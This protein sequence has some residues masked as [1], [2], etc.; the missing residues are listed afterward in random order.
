MGDQ[1]VRTRPPVTVGN[2]I[3]GMHRSIRM[4]D[5]GSNSR[6]KEI[7]GTMAKYE[8][9]Q[10]LTQQDIDEILIE[11]PVNAEPDPEPEMDTYEAEVWSKV[12]PAFDTLREANRWASH[13]QEAAFEAGYGE[14]WSRDGVALYPI[15]YVGTSAAMKAWRSGSALTTK[16][17]NT[18]ES[19]P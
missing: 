6:T 14:D 2:A 11:E 16:Y 17:R 8:A 15:A 13:A 4:P 9:P 18:V 5:E 12:S 7:V 3:T 19:R 10:G 1:P